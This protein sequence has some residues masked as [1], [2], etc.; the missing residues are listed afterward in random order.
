MSFLI[1]ALGVLFAFGLVIFVHEFGHFIVAKK[2]GVKVDRF[3]FGLGPE[4]VGFQW[5][6]TRYCLAW[7]PLGGE[8][9]MAGEMELE[10]AVAAAKPRDPRE[11]FAL[12][13]YRRIPIV[14]A[15]PA[16]NYVLSFFL[17]ALIAFAWGVPKPSP[18]ARVG[19]LAAGFPAAQ[20]GLEPGDLFLSIDGAPLADWP[21]MA[22]VIHKSAGKPLTLE[23]R[24][25]EKTFSVT[26]TP[27]E[28]GGR[29]LIG[30]TPA[31]VQEKQPFGASLALGARQCW[32]WSK[33]TLVYLGQKIARREKL[34]LSGPVGIA[35]VVAKATRSGLADYLFLIALVSVGIGLFNLFPIPMLDGGHLA[36]FLWEGLF[37]KPAPKK[38]VQAANMTG[39]A[40]LLSIFV[41]ATYSD[42][43]RLRTP[44]SA[45]S[46]DPK[47]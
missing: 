37:R 28:E 10:D 43:K 27:R 5:G 4:M 29:G 31:T 32:M 1:P 12:P 23:V 22:A 47:K 7:I 45:T 25:G 2:S 6:E 41:F 15:G 14:V 3:S 46:T 34:E 26:L 35:T 30:V 19:D 39:L 13:W 11:F 36:F 18:E 42:I 16:M 21:S 33:T 44:T 9:R 8:V 40:L 17:F 24:R 20:A 38:L